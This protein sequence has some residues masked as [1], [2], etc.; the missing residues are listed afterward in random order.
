MTTK[1]NTKN[2]E[3]RIKYHHRPIYNSGK[4]GKI[5][6]NEAYNNNKAGPLLAT[7]AIII[8]LFA[9]A[10]IIIN[11]AHR[12]NGN[13]TGESFVPSRSYATPET[14]NTPLV[15]IN[16]SNVEYAILAPQSFTGDLGRLADWHSKLG[17]RTKV[18]SLIP[19]L[20]FTGKDDAEKIRNFLIDLNDTSSSLKYVLLVGDNELIPAR[21]MY[22]G[23]HTWKLDYSY[24]SDH[25]YACLGGT[26]D[27]NGNGT[28][29]EWGE[30]DWTPDVFVGRIPI[31]DSGEVAGM[32]DKIIDYRETPP[33]GDWIERMMVWTSVM[34]PPNVLP[35]QEG[36]YQSYKDNAFEIHQYLDYSLPPRIDRVYLAD[37]NETEGGNYQ[38]SND[39]FTRPNAK[40]Q[41]DE[42]AAIMTFGGQAYYDESVAPMDNALANYNG[43]NGETDT[44]AIA[45]NYHDADGANNNGRMPFVFSTTCDTLNFS[46]T[47][48]T[49][50]ER[51]STKPTGGVI[52]QIGNSGRSWRGEFP[53]N[54][55][56]GNWWMTDKFW[57][58]FFQ[59]DG[60]AADA[61]YEVKEQ[62]ALTII[63]GLMT[64]APT[65][66]AHGAK[67]NLYG[68]NFLGDPALDIWT[69]H[70]RNFKN[71]GITLFE[72]SRWLNMTV[73]DTNSQAVPGARVTIELNGKYSSAT[74]DAQGRVSVPY[75]MNLGDHPTVTFHANGLKP[76]T[77]IA[78]VSTSPADLWIASSITLSD[79]TPGIG[80][81]VT[82]TA[83]VHNTGEL[84][85]NNV[86]VGFYEGSFE[87]RNLIGNLVDAG[88]IGISGS[89]EVSAIWV[90]K[91][92]VTGIVAVVDPE[93][94]VP[95]AD[96]ENNIAAKPVTV[97]AADL[98]L[99]AITLQSS[100]G[101]NVSTT[102][103]TKIS[104]FAH[105][106]GA[107]R[108]DDITFNVYCESVLVENKMGLDYEVDYMEQGDETNLNIQITPRPG[109]SQYIIAADPNEIIPETNETNNFVS[110]EMFG[111][112]PPAV[113]LED[114]ALG[115]HVKEHTIDLED[116]I[117]DPDTKKDELVVK[118]DH[119]DTEGVT[120][121]FF[122]PWE[123]D[124][125]FEDE[126]EGD[127]KLTITVSDGRGET[128]ESLTVTRPR[129]IEPPMMAAIPAQV[130]EIG[131]RLYLNVTLTNNISDVTYSDNTDLFDIH[132]STGKI[133]FLP[134]KSDIGTH[135]ITIT[136]TDQ[137]GQ[138]TNI[139]FTLTVE[140]KYLMLQL[141][142]KTKYNTEVNKVFRF[143][144]SYEVDPAWAD[145][146]T[147][148]VTEEYVSIDD[149]GEVT[150]KVEKAFMGGT[151]EKDFKF[152]VTIDDGK[153]K[154]SQT[155]TVTVVDPQDNTEETDK[156]TSPFTYV[157]YGLG[158]LMLIGLV[159]V[160]IVVMMARS[161]KKKMEEALAKVWQSRQSSM[162]RERGLE[163]KIGDLPAYDDEKEVSFMVDEGSESA[164]RYEE[165]EYYEDQDREYDE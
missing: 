81:D 59:M 37:Y 32:V 79:T 85:A 122:A 121:D 134:L 130:V 41:F 29:G 12:L 89:E 145:D 19:I 157:L 24:I 31:D 128:E 38:Y 60:R 93:N 53:G 110:F 21:Y 46:E 98:W 36:A 23:A 67:C 20:A 54:V 4:V 103:S 100:L 84:A 117:S 63:P 40:Q 158:V 34:V 56:K 133:E 104:I 87:A 124:L 95:E 115:A 16:D 86:K 73:E 101:Y 3:I 5:M 80:T 88:T 64:P 165:G 97:I 17:I 112:V 156:K 118:V 18:Y 13:V 15:E 153:G 76:R 57:N 48:D 22:A 33:Q 35:P 25:Y 82:I 102:A 146:V 163:K 127:V 147:F 136:V 75:L 96:E 90:A 139:T 105:N 39:N 125:Q 92:G 70:P 30:E 50:L 68:Y 116:N 155:Y 138:S 91:E 143:T 132:T 11:P 8:L 154:A 149:E 2:N 137:W 7:C 28:Y 144:V 45:Y 26:W 72:G 52:G 58:Y 44:W 148:S 65:P 126:F 142:G 161:K 109:W 62:Y 120:V 108:A 140:K 55:S 162:Q 71:S 83:M 49:N 107:L 131:G 160:L 66:A 14:R 159:V 77:V 94:G 113:Q 114:V 74:S 119:D 9:Q 135:D 1:Y 78:S 51:W 69:S 164:E 43:I 151:T 99:E 61:F 150:F 6:R 123:I 106:D 10:A 47:D 129:A 27:A 111:N 42:G 141:T 152:Q